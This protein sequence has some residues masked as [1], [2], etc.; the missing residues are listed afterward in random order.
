MFTTV[1]DLGRWG[2]QAFGVPVS[3]AMDTTSLRLANLLVGNAANAAALEAT[4][5]G[6]ELRFDGDATIA[7]T[8]GDLSATLDARA[9]ALNTAMPVRAGSVLR[10]GERRRGARAYIAFD[11]GI[12]TPPSLGSRSTHV[13]SGLGGLHGRALRAG[14]ALPLQAGGGASRRHRPVPPVV[15][16]GARLRVLPGPQDDVFG[17]AALDTLQRTRFTI[18]AHSD[19]MGYRLRGR[20]RIE[21]AGD[22]EMISDVT[23]AGGIQVPPSG[24]PILLMADRQTTG[25]YPQVATVITADL[26]AAGQLAPGDWMEFQLCTRADAQAALLAEEARLLA[27]D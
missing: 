10:F 7:V 13:M 5:T 2:H 20:A 21:R 6:P 11:G 25:G 16:G 27:F 17:P 3:G 24:N 26:P 18:T 15:A 9:V 22:R 8:G 12:A 14:D 1:Q 19:R 4:V 23:V